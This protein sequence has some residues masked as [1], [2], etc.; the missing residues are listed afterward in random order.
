MERLKDFSLT[1]HGAFDGGVV[2]REKRVYGFF[3]QQ[4]DYEAISSEKES[5]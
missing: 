4:N 5:Q 3:G 2:Q 1:R